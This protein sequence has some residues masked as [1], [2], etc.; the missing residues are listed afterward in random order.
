MQKKRTGEEQWIDPDDAPLLTKEMLDQAEI[1]EGDT[2][3]RRGRGRPKS[4]ATKEQINV[5][6]D[7]TVLA[8]LREAGPG[9]QFQ[10]NTLLGQALGLE[11]ARYPDSGAV[12]ESGIS[13]F[14]VVTARLR[15]GVADKPSR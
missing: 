5:R 13:V 14:K 7:R 15:S 1:F 8:K 9:W 10:I 12:P 3:V 11:R 2:F 4:A 6:I